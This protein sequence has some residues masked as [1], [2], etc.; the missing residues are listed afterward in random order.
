MANTDAPRGLQAINN[1]YGTVPLMEK[2]SVTASTTIY[3]G[4]PVALADTG[5]IVAASHTN[6]LT[7]SWIGVASHYVAGA[8]TDRSLIVYTDVNQEYEIQSDDASLTA[9]TDYKGALFRFTN[10]AAGSGTLKHS[11]AEIDG[12]S[13]TGVMGTAAGSV[14]PLRVER[15]SAQI[16]NELGA[17]KSWTKFLV[18]IA[19]PVMHRGMATVGVAGG[20]TSIFTGIL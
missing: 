5:L 6:A 20:T 8:A 10:I 12:S 14:T 3:E 18:K 9:I 1:P 11:K 15:I 19:P 13:A 7:G 17:S 16:N 4:Q 2:F